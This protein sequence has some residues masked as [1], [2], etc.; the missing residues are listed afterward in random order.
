MPEPPDAWWPAE[1]FDKAV[2]QGGWIADFVHATR[3]VETPTKFSAW[4]AIFVL[5]STIRRDAWFRWFPSPVYPN[6][7]II[8]VAPPRIC[9]KST[10]VRFGE[11]F[12]TA[13]PHYFSD[14]KMQLQKMPNMIRSKATPE[15]IGEALRPKQETYKI[16]GDDGKEKIYTVN[17]DSQAAVIISE[18][19]TFLGKQKYNE[20]LI[21][22]LTDLYDC[23][24]EDSE[25]TIGRGKINYKNVYLTIFGGTTPE[26]IDESIPKEAMKGGF[27]SRVVLVYQNFPSRTYPMPRPVSSAP[28]GTELTRRLAWVNQNAQGEY[29]FSSE[30]MEEYNS[31]YR[32]FKKKLSSDNNEKRK[33]LRYRYDIHLLKLS[34]LIRAQRYTPGKE[35]TIDDFRAAQYMLE[36]TYRDNHELTSEV[37][38]SQYT[39]AYNRVVSLLKKKKRTR[40][41][42]M[43]NCS[44]YGFT[45]DLVSKI[46]EQ[47]SQEGKIEA[48]LHGEP[49]EDLTHKGNEI[50]L[51]LGEKG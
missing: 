32:G 22:R 5:S 8:V 42:I 26:G 31:W 46:L 41:A 15:A 44:P 19:E 48:K 25:E 1:P 7:Y 50:Y 35:I 34:M 16:V 29:Y 9:P 17:T 40:R 51:W 49:Q 21:G 43:Q 10:S 30:A 36:E 13:M 20:G 11:K 12:I 45:A 23:K 4:S 33:D 37:G 39:K 3:G 24:D 2:P 27:M 47:L 14:P 28:D 6:F 18:L 38:V